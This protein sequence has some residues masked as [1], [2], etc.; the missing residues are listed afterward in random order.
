M[1]SLIVNTADSTQSGLLNDFLSQGKGSEQQ[2]V[3]GDKKLALLHRPVIPNPTPSNGLP[4]ADDF[5]SGDTFQIAIGNPDTPPTGGTFKLG[6]PRSATKTITSA[7]AANPSVISCIGHGMATGDIAIWSGMTGSTPDLNNQYFVVTVINS[8]SFSIPINVTVGG[9]G[10]TLQ[11]Y[12]TN[13]LTALA[14]NASAATLQTALS[15][16][17]TTEGYGSVVVTLFEPGNYQVAWSTTGAV[18]TLYGSGSGLTPSSG[19]SVNSTVAGDG[20]TNAVQVFELAQEPVAYCEPSTP[21]PVASITPIIAQ[22]GSAS[23]KTNKI[24]TLEMTTG[25][26]GGT[27]SLSMT[28]IAG[29][30]SAFV[31]NGNVAD[32][33]LANTLNLASGITAG[34][35]SVNRVGNSLNIQFQGTQAASDVPVISVSNIDLM[36]PMGVTGTMDLNTVNLYIAFAQTTSDTLNFT[37]AIRRTRTTGEDAEYFQNQVTLKRNIINVATMVQL[38]LPQ[39][40]TQSQI[41]QKLAAIVDGSGDLLIGTK[42]RLAVITNGFKIQVSTDGSTWQDGPSYVAS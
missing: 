4:W 22:H 2:F 33:D 28:T 1:L 24:Y 18:G 5:Q 35:I 3:K 42:A 25:T 9:T 38:T 10:G 27:F 6:V 11:S 32:S 36:A 21:L 23:P 8:N 16:T 40:Y 26:Y 12:N 13:G 37:F 34:D 19:V 31:V 15:S 20:E 14:Y 17:S 30:T 39:Y 29:V 7:S 41:D